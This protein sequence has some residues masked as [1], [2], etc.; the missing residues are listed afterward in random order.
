MKMLISIKISLNYVPKGQI[1]HKSPSVQV[2][3][4]CRKGDKPLDE[5]MMIQLNK[6]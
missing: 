2:M 4:W 3:A 6:A 1:D 5:P